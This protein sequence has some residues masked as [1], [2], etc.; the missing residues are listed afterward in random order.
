VPV[1]I[2][3]L[4]AAPSDRGIAIRNDVYKRDRDRM[5]RSG[6]SSGGP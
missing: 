6:R 3:Y 4:T 5:A 2:T 1:Y